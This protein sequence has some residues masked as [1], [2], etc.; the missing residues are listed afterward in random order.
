MNLISMKVKKRKSKYFDNLE[1][2][3]KI[4]PNYQEKDNQYIYFKIENIK[5]FWEN[6]DD[7]E[8]LFDKLI[9]WKDVQVKIFEKEACFKIDYRSLENYVERKFSFLP[10]LE[11][12]IEDELPLKYVFYQWWGPFWAFMDG[13]DKSSYYF[14]ECQ[15]KAIYN[16]IQLFHNMKLD[17][18]DFV[19][20]DY[21]ANGEKLSFF[22]DRFRK[23]LCFSCNNI[24]ATRTFCNRMYGSRFLQDY[25]WYV[26]T[27]AYE[28]SIDPWTD[29]VD[30]RDIENEVR[31]E[32]GYYR[33]GEKWISETKMYNIIKELFPKEEIIFHY[34]AEWL[35]F[36][37]IDVYLPNLKIGFEYQGKQHFEPIDFFGG[38]K[39]FDYQRAN[40]IKKEK[41][42][43]DYN[44]KLYKVNYDDQ[45]TKKF[46][47]QLIAPS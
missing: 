37:E 44:V 16:S 26:Y 3:F 25:G 2:N 29:I 1:K 12:T 43:Q 35:C 11:F 27:R 23:G 15:K 10:S 46:I 21:I 40:D 6:K 20:R 36:L 19:Y 45:L 47:K 18:P 38:K 42:C 4:M 33:I 8:K 17:F 22:N 31:E 39:K 5:D 9:K 14:C 41:L 34:R 13:K 32:Y 7:L 30:L 28:K 24:S